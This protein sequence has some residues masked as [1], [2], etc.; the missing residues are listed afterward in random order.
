MNQGITNKMQLILKIFCLVFFTFFNCLHAKTQIVFYQDHFKGAVS[1]IGFSSADGGGELTLQTNFSDGTI[2]KKAFLICTAIKGFHYEPNVKFIAINN[3]TF[4][5]NQYNS[6]RIP[7]GN[8][9]YIPP[10]A[11]YN[12]NVGVAYDITAILPVVNS[13]VTINWIPEMLPPEDCLGCHYSAPMLVLLKEDLTLPEIGVEV[14]LNDKNNDDTI[15]FNSLYIQNINWNDPVAMGI[16]SDRLGGDLSDG[17]RFEINGSVI[18]EIR[19]EDAVTLIGGAVGN[20]Y[21]EAGNLVGLTD[22]TTDAFFSGPLPNSGYAD[23]LA[24]IS[25]YLNNNSLLNFNVS[26]TAQSTSQHN[27]FVGFTIAYTSNCQTQNVQ[28]P[29]DTTLCLGETLQLAA[30]GGVQYE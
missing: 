1:Y 3:D 15:V 25:N 17:Y 22:D 11:D 2:L 30:S 27:T 21:Y 29:K 28:T 6:F 12:G 16:H 10:P 14:I 26:Y 5:L 8:N 7:I 19:S 24:N 20:F 18:G 9:T 4:E 13:T 23:G